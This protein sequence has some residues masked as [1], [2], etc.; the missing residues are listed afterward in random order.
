MFY[1]GPIGFEICRS[2]TL[3][4]NK[5]DTFASQKNL[6]RMSLKELNLPS[7]NLEK[8]KGFKQ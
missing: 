3:T 4:I 6:A 5:K 8:N 1:H 2:Y 7:N